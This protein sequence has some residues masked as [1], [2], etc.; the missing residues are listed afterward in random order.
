MSRH[1]HRHP[2]RA[3]DVD[4]DS[5][6]T[7]LRLARR[8]SAIARHTCTGTAASCLLQPN[9]GHCCAP[10][11]TSSLQGQSQPAILVAQVP[12]LDLSDVVAAPDLASLHADL[13]VVAQIRDACATWGFFQ[14]I[15]HGVTQEQIEAFE[16]A[17]M[18]FFAQ[19]RSVKEK[20]RRTEHNSKGWYDDELTKQ[21]VDWKEGFDVGA[22]DGSLDLVGLD[23]YNQW[24]AMHGF[25]ATIRS[26]FGAM[27]AL[28]AKLTGCM[29]LGLGMEP[30]YFASE[31]ENCHS[32]YLRLNHY[33]P[34]PD[35]PEGFVESRSN[36]SVWNSSTG[37]I[38]PWSISHHTDAGAVTVLHQTQVRSLQVL[39][40]RDD[41]WYDVEPLQGA[42][43][44][45]TGDIMRAWPNACFRCFHAGTRANKLATAMLRV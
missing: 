26:Y 21:R 29:A 3:A 23:G 18:G 25:E 30:T 31:F 4:V 17:M 43:V 34:C 15:N 9:G 27:E 13:P 1:R 32:S 5:D 12:T 36:A 16:A 2:A 42:F 33:P 44:I 41:T 14:V 38:D 28:S 11:D 6:T 20:V 19:D 39:Q 8:L 7:P 45:N 35:L 10:A 24:P 22:Q 40:P 37:D